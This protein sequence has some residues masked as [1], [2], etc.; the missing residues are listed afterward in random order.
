MTTLNQT[1][2]P[3]LA[4]HRRTSARLL[5]SYLCRAMPDIPVAFDGDRTVSLGPVS[6]HYDTRDVEIR[7]PDPFAV[8]DVDL[9]VVVPGMATFAAVSTVVEG[10][11]SGWQ[12][13]A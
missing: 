6:V 7:F 10:L 1:Q 11:V 13:T 9:T 3:V 4:A 12:V 8:G 2:D 5:H